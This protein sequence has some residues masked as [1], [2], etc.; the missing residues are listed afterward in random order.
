MKKKVKEKIRVHHC[1][2][3]TFKS[4]VCLLVGDFAEVIPWGRKTMLKE[5]FEILANT[6][7][8]DPPPSTCLGRTFHT[9]GGGSIIWMPR[10]DA[11]TFVHEL[12][13]AVSNI[14]EGK[15]MEQ[16]RDN[17]ETYAYL[18]QELYDQLHF[19]EKPSK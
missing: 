1:Y 4:D 19:A 10:Y 5:K 13:H 15:S 9:G 8:K 6:L 14:Y 3:R 12:V 11:G 17:E 2:V 16:T 7:E 18:M